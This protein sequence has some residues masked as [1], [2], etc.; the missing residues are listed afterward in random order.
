MTPASLAP[1]RE[2]EGHEDELGRRLCEPGVEPNIEHWSR[3]AFISWQ[4]D[5]S[6]DKL[7][8]NFSVSLS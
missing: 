8:Y 3:S 7:E 4:L 6:S 1:P 5:L 2:L